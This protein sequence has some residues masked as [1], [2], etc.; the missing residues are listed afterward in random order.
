MYICK[1]SLHTYVHTY[2]HISTSKVVQWL[3]VLKV[4]LCKRES[5]RE[6][7]EGCERA[8]QRGRGKREIES[9]R[10]CVQIGRTQDDGVSN[11]L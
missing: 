10:I 2:I 7:K 6:R 9:E 3:Q 4:Q 1:Y 8:R 11:Y 5:E